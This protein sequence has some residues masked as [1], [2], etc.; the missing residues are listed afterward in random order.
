M[1][2]KGLMGGLYRISE[3]IMRLSVTNLLWILCS[4]PFF[5]LALN[6]LGVSTIEEFNTVVLTMGIVS[7]FTLFPATAAM[8]TV[9]R[10]WITGEEDVPLFKTFFRGYK[11]NYLQSMIGG[12]F[13][14]LLTVILAVNFMFYW[15]QSGTFQLLSYLFIAFYVVLIVSAFHFFSI[16]VHFHMK[17]FQVLKNA[18]LITIGSPIRTIILLIAN[19]FVVFISVTKFNFLIPF[20]MGSVI[21]YMSFQTFHQI[22][23]KTQQ[24]IE[25]ERLKQE[26]RA[27]KE[28]AE[29]GMESA[30]EEADKESPMLTDGSSDPMTDSSDGEKNDRPADR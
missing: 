4:I 19:A 3:W 22:F 18:L 24:K 10:K 29:A 5:F 20:F 26:E 7:P 17:V 27:E 1:E 16:M 30:L 28:Q 13:Y 25:K 12:I 15:G 21:A 11:E 2:M 9:V 23:L 6:L 14:A 8:F